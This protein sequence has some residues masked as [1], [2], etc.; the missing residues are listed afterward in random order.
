[1]RAQDYIG[2]STSTCS[3]TRFMAAPTDVNWGGKVHGGNAMRWIDE[4]ATYAGRRGTAPSACRPTPVESAFI[5]RSRSVTWSRSTLG[6]CVP[7]S[8]RC[9]SLSMSDRVTCARSTCS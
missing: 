7:G 9:I 3:L 2:Q 1:M 8:R 5:G 6:C 4:T